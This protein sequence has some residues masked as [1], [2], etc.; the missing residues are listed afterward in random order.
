[1]VLATVFFSYN[2][3]NMLYAPEPTSQKIVTG[4]CA[5]SVEKS[6]RLP[7]A[8]NLTP[9]CP[10]KI[11][12][13]AVTDRHARAPSTYT[14]KALRRLGVAASEAVRLS[15]GRASTRAL[16]AIVKKCRDDDSDS[17]RDDSSSPR[18]RDGQLADL[19]LELTNAVLFPLNPC[20]VSWRGKG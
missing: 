12:G 3:I 16:H 2:F 6:M 17:E 14:R 1:M 19:P 10:F 15:E 13:A 4:A 18:R 9:S 7:P 20:L 11:C 8:F 5:A